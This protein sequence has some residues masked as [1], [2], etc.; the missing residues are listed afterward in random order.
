MVQLQVLERQLE[1]NLFSR[2][3]SPETVLLDTNSIAY[4]TAETGFINKVLVNNLFWFVF[5]RKP[6]LKISTL[7]KVVLSLA[8]RLPTVS[9]VTPFACATF[10]KCALA[11]AVM[12]ISPF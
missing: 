12:A 8:H 3:K 5:L 1:A 2:M 6:S 9:T 10:R 4:D 11:D 7:H